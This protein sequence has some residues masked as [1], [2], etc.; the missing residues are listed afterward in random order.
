VQNVSITSCETEFASPIFFLSSLD[1]R[2][3]GEKIPGAYLVD[4]LAVGL[5]NKHLGGLTGVDTIGGVD[6]GK[7]RRRGRRELKI[8]DLSDL[9]A[10]RR[11]K[12]PRR[13][14]KG[15]RGG[16]ATPQSNKS[17]QRLE[18]RSL[19]VAGV[20]GKEGRDR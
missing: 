17:W 19:V 15:V 10:L 1:D 3:G 12:S 11:R 2:R 18:P 20:Y 13:V 6:L 7:C 8:R 4:R 9:W 16:T 5:G 14:R